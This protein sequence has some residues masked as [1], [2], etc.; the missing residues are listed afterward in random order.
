[1]T[2]YSADPGAP[3]GPEHPD[4]PYPEQP[5]EPQPVE[6]PVDKRA[7]ATLRTPVVIQFI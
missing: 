5:E 6:I 2:A 7:S 3:T 4:I 1:M